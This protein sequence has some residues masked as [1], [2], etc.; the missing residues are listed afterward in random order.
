M[1]VVVSPTAR[2]DLVEAAE[3]Y[4]SRDPD[5]DIPVKLFAEFDATLALIQEHPEAF[6]LFDGEVR[7]AILSR[8]P[9]GLYY[10]VESTRIVVLYFK[11]MAQEEA[12]AL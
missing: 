5:A 10:A 3:W 9:Y 2:V 6:P 1:R 4:E 8:Y 7:R 11:A 12:P